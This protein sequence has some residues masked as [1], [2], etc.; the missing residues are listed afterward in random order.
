MSD[1]DREALTR[2]MLHGAEPQLF[3]AD[4][5]ASFAF[6]TEK[7]GFLV[8]YSWG[9]PPY[10]GQ[11]MR[12]GAR[13]NLRCLRLPFIDPQRREKEELLSASIT[14][15]D[16]NALFREYEAAGVPFVQVLTPKP[17]GARDFIIRDPDGNLILFAGP[18]R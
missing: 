1:V 15:D 10:Y 11:V 13:L 8:A 12:D 7:L 3:I 18:D 6:Y 16:A 2:P 5:A 4:M 14:V 17:W 9:T